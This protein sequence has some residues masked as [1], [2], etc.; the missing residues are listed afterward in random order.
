MGKTP[1]EQVNGQWEFED[2]DGNQL[3]VIWGPERIEL[4]FVHSDGETGWVNM[5]GEQLDSLIEVL[6]Q[7][8]EEQ[9]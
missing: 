5:T 3:E 6:K 7:A 8:R 9:K 2:E 1:K 4:S